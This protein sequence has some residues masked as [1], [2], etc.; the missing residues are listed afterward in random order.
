MTVGQKEKITQERVIKLFKDELG[1]EV[2]GNLKDREDNSNIDEALL[3]R[4]LKK[5]GVSDVLIHSSISELHKAT[6]DGENLYQRNKAVYEKLRYGV[7]V[8]E[9]V[10]DNYET[11]YLID[12]AKPANNHFAIAEEV[13][14]KGEKEKRP[15]I[16]LYINGIAIGVLELKRSTVSIG[17]G[18]RQNITNQQEKYIQSF[19]T[20]IQFVFAGSDTEGLRYGTIGTG[21][22][23]F[24]E[25]KEDIADN[26]RLSLDKYLSK[27]CNKERILE[28]IYDFILFDSGVK[29]LPRVHQ[30]FGI[31]AAQ[32]H[33]KIKH[34]GIIWH[35]QGSGK[36]IVMVLLAKW[37]LEF[38]PKARVVIITD[39][40][41][42]DKQIERVFKDANETI[43][44][45]KSGL[46]LMHKLASPTPRMLC[47]LIHKFGKK[48][49][50]IKDFIKEIKMNPPVTHGEL[51][52]FVDECH[53][54]QG[55]DLHEAMKAVLRGAVFIG[56]TGTPLL[57]KDKK[58]SL[59]IFGKS[60]ISKSPY[61]HTYKFNE[62]V[63]DKVVLDLVYEARDIDQ[64]LSSQDKVDLWFES[65]TKGL[66]EYK[67]AILKKTWGTMQNLFSSKP[68]IE[69]IVQ[70]IVF[71]F[72]TKP[73]LSSEKGNAILV[74]TSIYNACRYYK[75]FQDTELKN[76]VALI[77]SYD[78]NSKDI[79]TE[80]TGANTET[81]KQWIY[82]TYIEILK[83]DAKGDNRKWKSTEAY[84]D[85]AKKLFR[86]EPI[87]M[88][89]L[90][91]VDK[92]LTGFDA[93][94][95]SYIY[96][97]RSLQDHGLFQAICRTNR[98]DGE[99]KE[100]GYIVDYKDLFRNVKG[101]ISVYTSEL[102]DTSSGK[103]ESIDV[104][105]RLTLGKERLDN[106]IE[107]MEELL[108][109]VA[110]PK[111]TPQCIHYFCGNTEIPEDLKQ[112]EP[113]RT[114]LYSSVAN[115]V[116]SFANIANELEDAGYSQEEITQITKKRDNYIAI[117]AEIKRASGEELDIKP[118]EADMR[119][120][121]DMYI[122]AEDAR[123]VSTLDNKTILEVIQLLGIKEALQTLPA[124]IQKN[125]GA[126]AETIENNVRKSILK[127]YA[128]DPSF[129]DKLSLLLNT[130]IKE[131][132]AD[133]LNYEKYLERI[134]KIIY[135]LGKG[136]SDDTPS[137]LDT[138]GKVALYNNLNNDE[139]LALLID[140]VVRG[141]IQDGFR[142]NPAKE[143]IIQGKI[144]EVLKDEYQVRRI[145]KIIVN[146]SEY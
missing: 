29:K 134:Q 106:A 44:R 120:L 49:S 32:E 18:I 116:R 14:I 76:K 64:R 144:Y 81:E 111:E 59:E 92:L 16:V 139:D 118:Y 23:Y 90:I 1:Y 142:G 105:D 121:L 99:D 82:N 135:E 72:S 117:R 141:V 36:S 115:L 87:N 130:L 58:T 128:I 31:K 84:E 131:R 21:E 75:C 26:S 124:N 113:L 67:K 80:D 51:F 43:A 57:R 13:T 52:V 66:N 6:E 103:E 126:V 55:G 42:L 25:W 112:K 24:L 61:I 89:L 109:P 37:I 74:A 60:P 86:L 127:D 12:W 47:S 45:T 145:F 79:T 9:N 5:N 137:S 46:D 114:T 68:R 108:V 123:V 110:P 69:K 122:Q 27:M 101:A 30:Y 20:T 33:V 35:T 104:K 136:K 10:G 2:L 56:F 100:F 83:A 17:E 132:K 73:R 38:N 65:K 39:R 40:E 94:P 146:Q 63:E 70:D 96:L 98:L 50:D 19:F 143:R 133:A 129:Y 8:K 85:N 93:P 15:D 71:D 41:E 54:T 102:D 97:D 77:T 88:K 78:P 119:N 34:G 140:R 53:R 125:K 62:A 95:C 91:V 107:A 11:V 7:K 4:F 48:D 3:N 28:L 22:K 138:P